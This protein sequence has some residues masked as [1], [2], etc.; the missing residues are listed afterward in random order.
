[1]LGDLDETVLALDALCPRRRWREPS[2]W[3]L[4]AHRQGLLRWD[5]ALTL[6][7]CF[8]PCERIGKGGRP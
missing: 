6:Y 2:D 1:V 8:V 7:L 4:D 3:L 5:E